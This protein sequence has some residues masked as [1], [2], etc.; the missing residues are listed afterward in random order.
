[1]LAPREVFLRTDARGAG[2]AMPRV[3][4]AAV[5]PALSAAVGAQG[6]APAEAQ[7]ASAIVRP[8]RRAQYLAGRWLLR[9]AAAQVFGEDGYALRDS[10]RRPLV[11]AESGGPAAVSVSHSADLVVCAAGPVEALGIDVEQIRPRADWDGLAAWVLHPQERARLEA[12]DRLERW[13]C[14]YEAW[15]FKEALAKALG[16]GVFNFPFE[17]IAISEDGTIEQVPPPEYGLDAE[18]WRLRRLDCS[19]GFAAAVA[20]RA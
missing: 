6:L 10:G 3:F 4:A 14:F 20:W 11:V 18:N 12:S 1:M 8:E 16:I 19:P 9:H 7:R 5:P 2:R 13:T 15:T 17:R